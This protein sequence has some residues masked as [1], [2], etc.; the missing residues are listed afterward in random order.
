MENF[1]LTPIE[2]F[3]NE[4]QVKLNLKLQFMT[5][6]FKNIAKHLG[7]RADGA[8][9]RNQFSEAI[10]KGGKVI[11]D[12]AEVETI[13]NSFAD[14]CFAKLLLEF[15]M[16]VIKKQTSFENTSSFIRLVIINSFKQRASMYTNRIAELEEEV[17]DLK[18]KLD[19]LS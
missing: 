12:F 2:N 18:K 19:E 3:M 5:I 17:Y 10:K 4:C 1:D 13:S 16:S 9:V 15:D 6:P 7:T 11:F 8:I 14:E